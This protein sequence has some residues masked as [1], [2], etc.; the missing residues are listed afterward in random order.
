MAA[1]WGILRLLRFETN[2]ESPPFCLFLSIDIT[3]SSEVRIAA[4]ALGKE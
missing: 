1:D 4:V 3:G 2:T